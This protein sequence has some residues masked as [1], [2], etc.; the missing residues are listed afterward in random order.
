M[1]S[2]CRDGDG[3]ILLNVIEIYIH[4][5]YTCINSSGSEATNLKGLFC[6]I[7]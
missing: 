1:F 6:M 7:I 3:F 2:H 4:D 5:L